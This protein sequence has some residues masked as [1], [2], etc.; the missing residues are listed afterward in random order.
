MRV[1]EHRGGRG[2]R[3][4]GEAQRGGVESQEGAWRCRYR[5]VGCMVAWVAQGGAGGGMC[6]GVQTFDVEL[7]GYDRGG[8]PP[9]HRTHHL[10]HVVASN[11]HLHQCTGA[12][13]G[14]YVLVQRCWR[15]VGVQRCREGYKLCD[16]AF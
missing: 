16:E 3:G 2:G 7:Q 10:A 4:A 14:A 9:Q 5:Y 1:R 15:G 12:H 8:V 13:V 6:V 11:V